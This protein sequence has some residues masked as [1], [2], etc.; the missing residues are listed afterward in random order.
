MT[1]GSWLRNLLTTVLARLTRRDTSGARPQ[2]GWNGRPLAGATEG[3][4]SPDWPAPAPDYSTLT[5][6]VPPDAS[7]PTC[8]SGWDLGAPV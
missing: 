8:G 6:F 4:L 3:G 1:I 7:E 5:L 2:V